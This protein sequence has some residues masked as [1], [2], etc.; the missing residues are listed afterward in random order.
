MSGLCGLK[1]YSIFCVLTT[2][3][4]Y[5]FIDLFVL[6]VFFSSENDA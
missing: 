4:L 2:L 5:V 6:C 1:T 3:F